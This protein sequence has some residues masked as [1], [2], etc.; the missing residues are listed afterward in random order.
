MRSQFQE[1]NNL[2]PTKVQLPSRLIFWSRLYVNRWKYKYIIAKT[3]KV[4]FSF[5]QTTKEQNFFFLYFIECQW[6]HAI[7]KM[8]NV[9]VD[10]MGAH[11]VPKII[12]TKVMTNHPFLDDGEPAK[13]TNIMFFFS[14]LQSRRCSALHKMIIS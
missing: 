6:T 9:F 8:L 10:H 2:V 5:C 4:V 11:A 13:L 12:A 7:T 1:V 14:C 3:V